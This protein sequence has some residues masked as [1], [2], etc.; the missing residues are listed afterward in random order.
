MRRS[1]LPDGS[2]SAITALILIFLFEDR[3]GACGA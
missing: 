1:G 3:S 2:V